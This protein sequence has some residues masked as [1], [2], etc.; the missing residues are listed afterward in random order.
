M[1]HKGIMAT[2]AQQPLGLPDSGDTGAAA[3]E[4]VVQVRFRCTEDVRMHLKIRAAREKSTVEQIVLKAAL[5]Y[6]ES[7][8]Q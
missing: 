1:S 5:R 8:A 7:A 2:I 6:L 3:G 4:P